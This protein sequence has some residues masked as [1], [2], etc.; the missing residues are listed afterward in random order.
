MKRSGKNISDD[1]KEEKLE[2]LQKRKDNSKMNLR[3]G[4]K[5]THTKWKST[6]Q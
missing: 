2:G 6:C 1:L 3:I 4:E 5:S